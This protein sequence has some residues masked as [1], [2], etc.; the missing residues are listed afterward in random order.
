MQEKINIER[1]VQLLEMASHEGTPAFEAHSAARQAKRMLDA[2]NLSF[3][4]IRF[5]RDISDLLNLPAMEPSTVIL[6]RIDEY[7]ALNRQHS[8]EIKS[9]TREVARLKAENSHLVETRLKAGPS[10]WNPFW[11][12]V[13]G[14]L[15]KT[16]GAYQKFCDRYNEASGCAINESV[17]RRWA[18]RDEV[19]ADAVEFAKSPKLLRPSEAESSK[20]DQQWTMEELTEAESLMQNTTLTT[21]QIASALSK[22]FGRRMDKHTVMNAK[23][24]I[25]LRRRTLQIYDDG[26]SNTRTILRVLKQEFPDGYGVSLK[27]V[28]RFIGQMR[29]RPDLIPRAELVPVPSEP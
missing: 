4:Q 28:H 13:T 17:L 9:L 6:R 2:A 18:Q 7:E 15:Q 25:F 24:R 14:R 29:D 22:R 19:P 21:N 12:V 11:A 27:E 23:Q 10:R 20:S 5:R 16:H 26:E 1:F 8:A 3:K